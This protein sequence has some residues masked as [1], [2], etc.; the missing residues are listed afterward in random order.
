MLKEKIQQNMKEAMKAG[1]A[2][3]R[4][5]L[6]LLQSA[7]KNKELEKRSKLSKTGADADKLEELS[8]LSDEE[9]IDVISSEVKKRKESIESYE[10]AGR[11]E[12]A[13]KER[14]ELAILMEYM[15]EQMSEDEIRE[16]AKKAIAEIGAKDIKE[17]GK[18]LGAL[19]PKLKG[20]ADG[21]TV[22]KIVKEELST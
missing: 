21:Q 17:M 14:D 13:R 3:R 12:L 19:M 4:L 16:E 22:S 9:I 7:I 8:L 2:V 15:P 5:V 18:V 11:E 10:N 20:R 6:S 1:D